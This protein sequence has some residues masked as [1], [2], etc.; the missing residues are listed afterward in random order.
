MYSVNT[1]LYRGGGL[2]ILDASYMLSTTTKEWESTAQ[3]ASPLAYQERSP[4]VQNKSSN[5][6]STIKHST[7]LIVTDLHC[8]YC[9]NQGV[10]T[11]YAPYNRGWICTC[12][13]GDALRAEGWIECECGQALSPDHVS[14]FDPPLCDRCGADELE[15]LAYQFGEPTR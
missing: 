15:N 5:P 3:T 13:H 12:E 9:W 11:R 1:C 6:I 10:I 8:P 2:H 4:D 7:P 14:D